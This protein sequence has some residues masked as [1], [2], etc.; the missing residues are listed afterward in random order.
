[1]I[2]FSE[3]RAGDG[4]RA[5][6]DFLRRSSERPGFGGRRETIRL[7]TTS[8]ST[9]R[10]YYLGRCRAETE[11][12]NL[13]GGFGPKNATSVGGAR[14]L[15][16]VLNDGYPAAAEARVSFRER[17]LNVHEKKLRRQK[18]R[19][20][21]REQRIGVAHVQRRS[22]RSGFGGDFRVTPRVK[23]LSYY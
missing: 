6:G 1:M 9:P 23:R 3:P 21:S 10:V 20:H 17:F 8:S 11:R 2:F 22:A 16:I 18:Q 15:S 19:K 5:R 4:L 7:E 14:R 13:R 12:P